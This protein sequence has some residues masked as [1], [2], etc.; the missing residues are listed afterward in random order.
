MSLERLFIMSEIAISITL[1]QVWTKMKT[2][3]K[4]IEMGSGACKTKIVIA[5]SKVGL[6]C[7]LLR[8]N[9]RP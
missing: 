7:P 9:W 5:V 6:V 1:Q 3:T 4:I 2:K 8:I